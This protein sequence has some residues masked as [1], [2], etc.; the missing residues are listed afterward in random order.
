MTCLNHIVVI[1]GDFEGE[2]L[3]VQ[4]VSDG[5]L[6]LSLVKIVFGDPLSS[7]HRRQPLLLLDKV[8]MDPGIAQRPASIPR[9]GTG[10]CPFYLSWALEEVL[11]RLLSCWLAASP[12][13]F[14]Q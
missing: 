13:I 3:G 2:G 5:D 12:K 4:T 7:C 14:H 10:F 6:R 8:S 9:A 11:E 1:G